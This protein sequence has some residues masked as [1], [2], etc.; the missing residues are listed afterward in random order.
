MLT[1]AERFYEEIRTALGA[2]NRAHTISPDPKRLR[3]HLAKKWERE[4]G[5]NL[6]QVTVKML[7]ELT[8]DVEFLLQSIDTDSAEVEMTHEFNPE[9]QA[10]IDEAAGLL[11]ELNKMI[12]SDES[13]SRFDQRLAKTRDRYLKARSQVEPFL[14]LVYQRSNQN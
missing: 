12:G 9:Q 7:R 1:K 14:D 11:S 3:P 10:Q 8:E 13:G 6:L 5:K 4:E 2:I